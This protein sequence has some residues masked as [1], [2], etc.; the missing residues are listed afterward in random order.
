M[1]F[2]TFLACHPP[3][4]TLG[5]TA[6]TTTISG[7][8][9]ATSSDLYF[10]V[11]VAIVRL[12]PLQS[13]FLGHRQDKELYSNVPTAV[14][15]SASVWA[16]VPCS[17][18]KMNIH[19]WERVAR[20]TTSTTIRLVWSPTSPWRWCKWINWLVKSKWRIPLACNPPSNPVTCSN[21]CTH[22]V[23]FCPPKHT[24][25]HTHTQKS[26]VQ[27]FCCYNNW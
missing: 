3:A 17:T 4:P 5:F 1:P 18:E 22:S 14:W 13:P 2:V 27:F 25:T 16:S 10:D 11:S 6:G 7:T 12:W 8:S 19:S 20:M 26:V 23:I 24:H 9:S 21:V 15:T